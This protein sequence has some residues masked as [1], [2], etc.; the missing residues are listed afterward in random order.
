MTA[1]SLET[2]VCFRLPVSR[3]QPE[4]PHFSFYTPDSWGRGNDIPKD[5]G[6]FA[7]LLMAWQVGPWEPRPDQALGSSQ[8]YY[9]LL[10]LRFSVLVWFGFAGERLGLQAIHQRKL[11]VIKLIS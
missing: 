3:K 4:S 6:L 1:G 7:I 10:R 5:P 11:Q 9:Q 2:W 8:N